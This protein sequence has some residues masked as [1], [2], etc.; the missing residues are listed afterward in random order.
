M[1]DIEQ[2]SDGQTSEPAA[3]EIDLAT[4]QAQLA[5]AQAQA[6]EYLDQARRSAAELSNARRRM[7]REAEELRAA[8]AERML[9]KLLP[10][11]DDIERAFDNL[12]ANLAAAEIDWLAGFRGIQRKLQ[13][14]LDSEGVAVIQTADQMFDP[15]LHYAITHEEAAGYAE[16]QIIAEVARGYKLGDKVLRPSMV[17]VAKA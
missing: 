5:Q 1:S 16:G 17:R 15:S 12:P 7:Q 3:G 4:V 10:I 2:P 8:A 6:A 14:L 9:E 13:G 11:A